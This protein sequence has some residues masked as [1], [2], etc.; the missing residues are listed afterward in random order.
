MAGRHQAQHCSGSESCRIQTEHA[1]GLDHLGGAAWTAA[2]KDGEAS[3]Q[4]SL[5]SSLGGDGRGHGMP[6]ERVSRCSHARDPSE[7]FGLGGGLPWL[8]TRDSWRRVGASPKELLVVSE[9]PRKR[10]VATYTFK[11]VIDAHDLLRQVLQKMAKCEQGTVP[12]RSCSNTGRWGPS[13]PSGSL[14]CTPRIPVPRP[15]SMS[16]TSFLWS[17][18]DGKC[19]EAKRGSP[20]QV[21]F[22]KLQIDIN[23]SACGTCKWK[24]HLRGSSW[25]E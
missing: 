14:P 3:L 13:N 11:V 5:G 24:V 16:A 21:Y 19:A 22:R 7:C 12:S 17:W 4:R 10:S 23:A 25:L 2:A 6:P 20:S 8:V 18:L 15:P 1:S 9:S